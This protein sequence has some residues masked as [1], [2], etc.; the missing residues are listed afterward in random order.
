MILNKTE[1]F[2]RFLEETNQNISDFEFD[3]HQAAQLFWWE[4]NETHMQI[5]DFLLD[6]END[7]K[8][9]APYSPFI[10]CAL[11]ILPFIRTVH[12]PATHFSGIYDYYNER[13]K[14]MRQAVQNLP[15]ALKNFSTV[16]GDLP[17]V[18][19]NDEE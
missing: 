15:K 4:I 18:T 6:Y 14:K 9:L 19:F 8:L 1:Q 11:K 10:T 3:C 12:L 5:C 2:I 16:V 7:I 13:G 17:H